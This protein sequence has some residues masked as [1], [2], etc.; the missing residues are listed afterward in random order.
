MVSNRQWSLYQ[1]DS[2][3]CCIVGHC[4]VLLSYVL[5]CFV[6]HSFVHALC[7]SSLFCTALFCRHAICHGCTDI[8]R[9]K[10]Y[11]FGVN[12][13]S[14]HTVFCRKLSFAACYGL[15]V[16]HLVSHMFT[17]GNPILALPIIYLLRE[18]YH[19]GSRLLCEEKK[20]YAVFSEDVAYRNLCVFFWIKN[21]SEI[22]FV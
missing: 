5:Q 20:V 17:L 14:E 21:D 8:I 13:R 4:S 10:Y 2:T 6:Q 16:T 3:L 15:S 18:I 7:C 22:L 11:F 1:M 19:W 9:L 12:F